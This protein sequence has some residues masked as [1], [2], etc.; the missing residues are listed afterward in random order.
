MEALKTGSAFSKER[1]PK[2][3]RPNRSK[4]TE[5]VGI[6]PVTALDSLPVCSFYSSNSQ[7]KIFPK[8]HSRKSGI[9]SSLTTNHEFCDSLAGRFIRKK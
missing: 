3:P 7:R 2:R 6:L 4:L 8:I 1:G 9:L 5:V